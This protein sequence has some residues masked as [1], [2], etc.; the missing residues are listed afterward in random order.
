M[1]PQSSSASQPP[2][3]FGV[4]IDTSRFGHH[5]CLLRHDL[6]PASAEFAFPE[7]AE[8]YQ[9]LRQ[10]LKRILDGAAGPAHF[11]IR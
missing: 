1:I 5:A 9:L 8:G 10:T 3:R 2:R 11:S 4:G 6:Q 7:S